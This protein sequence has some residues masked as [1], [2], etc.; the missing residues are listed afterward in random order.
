MRTSRAD[1]LVL[2]SIPLQLYNNY[3]EPLGLLQ[4]QLLILHVSDF[5][6]QQVVEDIWKQLLDGGEW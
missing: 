5:R 6:D 1:C 3:A 4:C 2:T